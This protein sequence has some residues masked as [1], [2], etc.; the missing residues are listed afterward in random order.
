MLQRLRKT[1]RSLDRTWQIAAFAGAGFLVASGLGLIFGRQRPA[2]ARP[3]GPRGGALPYL[4]AV[5]ADQGLGGDFVGSVARLALNES[6]AT[7]ALPA[8]GY[9]PTQGWGVFQ[10]NAAAWRRLTDGEQRVPWEATEDEEVRLPIERD[11][12]PIW[13]RVSR[14]GGSYYADRAVRLWHMAP[15]FE[16]KFE[17]R[18]RQGWS[19]ARAWA[20]VPAFYLTP[21][22][23]QVEL[24]A[25][26]DR[27]LASVTYAVG[28]SVA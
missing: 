2:G 15:V 22:G 9:A 14:H 4:K 5:A 24:R 12:A 3:A 25:K 19:P 20:E 26:I 8:A 27:K 18:L 21:S 28:P 1:Y 16:R 10:Y 13:R 23:R 6:G 11:Y 7:F 17:E